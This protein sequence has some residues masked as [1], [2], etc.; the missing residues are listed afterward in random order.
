MP[1]SQPSTS[2]SPTTFSQP[3]A[4]ASNTTNSDQ[5]TY[6][7][8]TCNQSL[9]DD[10]IG[11]DRCSNWFCPSSMCLGLPDQLIKGIL[12]YGGNA[13][14]YICT[15]CRCNDPSTNNDNNNAGIKQL[16][17]TV[18]M[19]CENVTKLTAQVNS[20]S[21]R[22][23][24]PVPPPAQLGT[25]SLP[26]SVDNVGDMR[27]LMRQEIREMSER[28]KRVSS[29]IVRGIVSQDN[30]QFRERFALITSFLLGADTVVDVS[31]IVCISREKRL[32]RLKVL[33][34][35]I[36]SRIL[37]A[38]KS[39]RDSQHSGVFVSRDLT[40][41]QRKDLARRKQ[42][43]SDAAARGQ[44]QSVMSDDA[45]QQPMAQPVQNVGGGANGAPST[46]QS[47]N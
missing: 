35:D 28:Q 43:R 18:K 10:A 7:C 1:P 12:D 40:F 24:V 37:D 42:A 9:S 26:S 21:Q 8:S 16:C 25:P 27:F 39:L 4:Q 11:C 22:P 6:Y 45:P 46:S 17:Q 47:L 23:P 33:N 41:A 19:L 29:L 5:D 30:A 32:Y 20:L 38:A 14:A 31:D 13:I 2:A 34:S 3:C 44:T 15:A 36:R